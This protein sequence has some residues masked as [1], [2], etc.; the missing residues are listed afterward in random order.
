MT[1]LPFPEA[2]TIYTAPK[3][4]DEAAHGPCGDLP[5]QRDE[6]RQTVTSCWEMTPEELGK[7]AHADGKIYL[8]IHGEQPPVMLEVR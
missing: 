5:V 4:W 8:T 6:G 2:N 7:F 1:P 3:G